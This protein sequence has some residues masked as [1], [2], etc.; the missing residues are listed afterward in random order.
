[1]ADD[2]LHAELALE[3]VD[4]RGALHGDVDDAG[5]VELEDHAPLQLGG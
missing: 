1:M 4:E 3:P 2:I 5:A